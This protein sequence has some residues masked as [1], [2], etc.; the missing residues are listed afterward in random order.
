MAISVTTYTQPLPTDGSGIRVP[1]LTLWGQLLGIPAPSSTSDPMFQVADWVGQWFTPIFNATILPLLQAAVS[2]ELASGWALTLFWRARGTERN[3]ATFASGPVTVENRSNVYVDVSSPAAVQINNGTGYTFTSTGPAP[4][5][6]GTM[7]AAVGST[8]P[9]TQL[10]FVADTTGTNANTAALAIPG[11]PAQLASGPPGV[12][13]ATS[14]SSPSAGNPALFGG[15]EEADTALTARGRAARAASAPVS[16]NDKILAVVLGTQ[17]APGPPPVSVAT[18]KVRIIG[19]NAVGTVYCA[20]PSGPTPGSLSSPGS[21]LA[22]IAAQVQL[23]CSVTGLSLAVAAATG[24]RLP[25]SGALQIFVYVDPASNVTTAAAALTCAAALVQ[26]EAL[27]PIGGT[28]YAQGGQG[29]VM[30]DAFLAV[31]AQRVSLA[32]DGSLY[33]AA[34]GVVNVIVVDPT[35][36]SNLADTAVAANNCVQLVYAINVVPAPQN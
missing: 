21:E 6:T 5:S 15:N 24:Q 8:Y 4:G 9:Q 25:S 19:A 32:G 31:C 20:T 10:L 22:Q 27:L 12:Y 29:Y 30:A 7:A 13:V 36:S 23:L 2:A 11:Y 33:E 16:T 26:W 3:G 14:I 28:R 35:T 34:P 1:L 17:L 18:S